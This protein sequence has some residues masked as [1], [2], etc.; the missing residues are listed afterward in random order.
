[1]QYATTAKA[2]PVSGRASIHLI[3]RAWGLGD[4]EA[5]Q[6]EQQFH[7]RPVIPFNLQES[8]ISIY[9]NGFDVCLILGILGLNTVSRLSRQPSSV[10]PKL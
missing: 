6:Q 1:M 7:A 2:D 10:I 5:K 8:W 3:Q 4:F 9:F